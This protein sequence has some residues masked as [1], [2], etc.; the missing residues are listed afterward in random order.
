MGSVFC[1][2]HFFMACASYHEHIVKLGHGFERGATV[3][4]SE[5]NKNLG[6]LFVSLHWFNDMIVDAMNREFSIDEI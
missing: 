4:L 6:R 5:M 1:P 2:C 3:E